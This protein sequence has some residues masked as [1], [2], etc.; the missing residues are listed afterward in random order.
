MKKTIKLLQLIFSFSCILLFASCRNSTGG[1]VEYRTVIFNGS[2]EV[3]EALLK[4]IE[5]TSYT[6]NDNSR[7][8]QPS[9]PASL[10]FYAKA[11]NKNDSSDSFESTDLDSS[12]K[13]FSIPLKTGAVW[14]IEVGA[15]GV[16]ALNSSV[17]D[18]VLIK[19]TFEFNPATATEPR[20][21]H[22]FYLVPYV[23]ANGEGKLSLEIQIENPSGN[24][25]SKVEIVPKKNLIDE[26]KKTAGWSSILGWSD[27]KVIRNAATTI[28]I[29][30]QNGFTSGVWEV[31]INFTDNE[32]QLLFSSTQIIGV[33][34]NLKT[35][36][37]ELSKTTT[38]TNEL[39]KN[40][41]FKLTTQLIDAYGLTDFYV[42][43]TGASDANSGSPMYPLA[44]ISKA[45]SVVNGINRMDKTYTIHVKNGVSEEYTGTLNVRSNIS[46]ECYETIYGDK[47]GTATISSA[48]TSAIMEITSSDISSSSL[49]IEGVKTA[50]GW[51]GLKLMSSSNR[52]RTNSTKGVYLDT[53]CSFFMNGGEISGYIKDSASPDG[54]A[55]GPGVYVSGNAYF[56]MTGGKIS[57]FLSG[58]KGA[59]VYVL[60]NGDFTM[61]GGTITNNKTSFKGGGVYVAGTMTVSG[62]VDI[63]ENTMYSTPDSSN[64]YLPT[65]KLIK[66]NGS[67]DGSTIGITTQGTPAV[68][69][70]IRL[71]DGYAYKKEW[72]QNGNNHPYKYFVSDKPGFS[73]LTDPTPDDLTT[74]DID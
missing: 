41:V 21:N 29:S 3:E 2:F 64:V 28:L 63:S 69:N 22:K 42:G 44:K 8:A 13:T 24:K 58:D 5:T 40:G 23:T 43:G 10:T 35:D 59:G 26:S 9:L 50:N 72:G 31:A 61:K 74:L 4:Q 67:L 62:T 68:G 12:N 36:K 51:T 53:N 7:S 38:S 46:I 60:E 47:K 54:Y 30:S 52:T 48:S 49:T 34:D 27:S 33:Y 57:N 25:I 55:Y 70:N 73:V 16:S 71:T 56:T 65:G 39:I 20:F 32:G 19:D 17:T 66:V 18:A 11:T 37:W 15:K 14:I 6:A 1:N 45:I